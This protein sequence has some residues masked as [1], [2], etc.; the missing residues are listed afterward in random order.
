MV[1]TSDEAFVIY[2]FFMLLVEY[3]GGEDSVPRVFNARR[4]PEPGG[5]KELQSTAA[6]TYVHR[7]V[8]L[9]LISELCVYSADADEPPLLPG[10]Q[11]PKKTTTWTVI[12]GRLLFF[13]F[14]SH[15]ANSTN[16][17]PN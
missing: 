11:P 1:V 13:W 7:P 12:L 4:L 17:Q 2:V 9:A 16:R 14:V 5:E 10:E 3:I 6:A 15:R 8:G